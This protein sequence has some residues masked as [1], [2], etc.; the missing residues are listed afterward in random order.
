MRIW[1]PY[2]KQTI[3]KTPMHTFKSNLLESNVYKIGEVFIISTKIKGIRTIKYDVTGAE[4]I[5]R[6]I[7]KTLTLK[8]SVKEILEGER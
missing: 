6:L 3:L 4:C 8:T 5:A 7:G 1:K 2:I